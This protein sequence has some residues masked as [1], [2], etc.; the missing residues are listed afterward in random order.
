METSE[1][2]KPI[3][4]YED[5]YEVSNTGFVRSLKRA[6]TSGK[7]LKSIVDKDGYLR[8]CLCKNNVKKSRRVHRL[9]ANAFVI[10]K[11]DTKKVINH[12]NENKADNRAENLEWCTVK[13]NTEYGSG[14]ERRAAKRRKPVIAISAD[15]TLY[16]PSITEASN[17]LG[18]SH[19]NISECLKKARSRKT[20]RGFRFEKG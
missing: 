9:V 1:Q 18:V 13:Y 19:G 10:G 15:E 20:L 5:L 4:G 2:W 17:V 16:F 14:I 8:V 12:I 3:N 11:T 7:I 6:S